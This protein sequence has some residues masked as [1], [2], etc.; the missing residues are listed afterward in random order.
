MFYADISHCGFVIYTGTDSSSENVV[1]TDVITKL[2]TIHT[3]HTY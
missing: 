1:L 2:Y 3:M